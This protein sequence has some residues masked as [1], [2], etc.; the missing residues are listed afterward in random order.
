MKIAKTKFKDLI[1]FKSKNIFDKRG[2]FRELAI[3]KLIRKRLVFTILSI[4]K[5]KC[6]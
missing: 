3:E 4:S 5:K 2:K 6:N 1:V